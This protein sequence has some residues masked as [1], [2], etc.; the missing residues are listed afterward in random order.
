M[1]SK[2]YSPS[3][4]VEDAMDCPDKG[5]SDPGASA[6]LMNTLK[7]DPTKSL[8]KDTR[9]ASTRKES[10][11]VA[12]ESTILKDSRDRLATRLN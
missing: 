5:P 3:G 12:P 2:P 10:L 4:N 11:T 7:H 9:G 1:S 6:E 8:I